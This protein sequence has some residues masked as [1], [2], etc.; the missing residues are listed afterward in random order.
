[1]QCFASGGRKIIP[2]KTPPAWKETPFD[3]HF[4]RGDM[5]IGVTGLCSVV[6]G[7]IV[8]YASD[9]HPAHIEVLET[10]AGLLVL[11]GFAAAGYALSS[12]V[13]V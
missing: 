4:R 3:K 5:M 2:A 1:M 9:R 11:G 8:A 12:F 6:I 13:I 7:A 10:L